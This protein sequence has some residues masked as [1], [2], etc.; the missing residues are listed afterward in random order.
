MTL[1]IKNLMELTTKKTH[2]LAI[3]KKKEAVVLVPDV[4][5]ARTRR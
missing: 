4:D 3:E 2:V 1:S 5:V